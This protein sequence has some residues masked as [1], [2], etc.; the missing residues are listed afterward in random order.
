MPF[1]AENLLTQL[2]QSEIIDWALELK[3]RHE[4]YDFLKKALKGS[5]FN[6]SQTRNALHALFRIGYHERAPEIL[7]TFVEFAAHPNVEI[8]S[9]AVQLAIGLAR[10]SSKWEKAPLL[11]SEQQERALPK[12]IAEGVTPKVAGLAK[13]FFRS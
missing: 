1:S 13:D 2:D 11:L 4:A 3:H 7:Q 9:E 10:W 12:A 5:D 8:R 6:V